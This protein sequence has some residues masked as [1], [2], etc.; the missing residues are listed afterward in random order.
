MKDKR[1]LIQIFIFKKL[2][3]LFFIGFILTACGQESQPPKESYVAPN[4][5]IP[6]DNQY[7]TFST[8]YLLTITKPVKA[9]Q[10]RQPEFFY[11]F[12]F[13]KGQNIFAVPL[14]L[15]DPS[16]GY[17]FY[18][19]PFKPS[20]CLKALNRFDVTSQRFEVSI[21]YMV[22]GEPW[23]W[24]PSYNNQDFRTLKLGEGYIIEALEDCE[25]TVFG[26]MFNQHT[27]VVID[28]MPG[29]NFIGW[30]GK[31]T[32]IEKALEEIKGKWDEDEGI[33]R[34]NKESTYLGLEYENYST[35]QKDF[36]SFE[37]ANGYWI[38]MLES[39]TLR[40]KPKAS[41]DGVV[42]SKGLRR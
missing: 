17:D 36:T 20:S 13:R 40:Y 42:T 3:V 8:D 19:N 34:H 12:R 14:Q 29:W 37:N 6:S 27:E 35:T 22:Y 32:K 21:H 1:R 15:T 23:G 28:L 2:T 10:G 4:S 5:S 18:E 39:A 25:V 33:Y 26:K 31:K 41:I 7:E 38:Y 11:T 30:S 24:W 16:L 9:Q